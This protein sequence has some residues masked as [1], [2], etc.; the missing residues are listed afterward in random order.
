VVHAI[1]SLTKAEDIK[2]F[3]A[4]VEGRIAALAR[5]HSLLS[6]SRWGGAKIADLIHGELAAYRSPNLAR[7][8]ISGNSLSLHP[9]AVQALALAVHELATNAAKYGALSVSSGSVEVTWEAHDDGLEL[10]WIERGGPTSEPKAQGGF[11]MRVI[12]AS[13]ETQLSGT[14]EFD[15]QQEG[16]QC[17]IRVPCRPKI[18]LFDNLWD[19]HEKSDARHSDR[20]ELG[21]RRRIPLIRDESLTPSLPSPVSGGGK[22]GESKLARLDFNAVAHNAPN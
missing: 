6:D 8:W 11:G 16:L 2:Q 21:L 20:C 15:W 5:A 18:E 14:V 7:V 9:S 4:A 3:S 17:V 12:K 22:G 1:V 13:V 19:S 10:R